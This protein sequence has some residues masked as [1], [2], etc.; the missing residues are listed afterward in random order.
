M[1]SRILHVEEVREQV[2]VGEDG[3]SNPD[4]DNR[5]GGNLYRNRNAWSVLEIA[6]GTVNESQ[7]KCAKTHQPENI[8]KATAKKHSQRFEKFK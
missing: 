8:V 1:C 7:R 4:S 6:G 5:K 2:K 3:D